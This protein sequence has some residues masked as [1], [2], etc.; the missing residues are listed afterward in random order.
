MAGL[1]E[2][3]TDK[4]LNLQWNV[5]REDCYGGLL[6]TSDLTRFMLD[7]AWKLVDEELSEGVTSVAAL[8]QLSHEEPTPS[9]ET[10]T[11]QARVTDVEDNVIRIAFK[12]VDETGVIAHGFNERHVVDESNL[13]KISLKRAEMLKT[14]LD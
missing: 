6:S 11:V 3:L 1:K 13:K 9:G 4:S 5:A 10:V 7:T 14:L 2:R 12:A 8:V